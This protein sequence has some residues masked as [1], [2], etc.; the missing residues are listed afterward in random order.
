M[1]LKENKILTLA[2][3]E[4]YAPKNSNLTDDDDIALRLNP[5]YSL[6][7]QELA[8]KKKILKVYDFEKI[9]SDKTFY[10]EYEL[11]VDLY[12]IK[13]IIALDRDTYK[14]MEA[15]Y[16][17][18]G[19]NIYINDKS[20]CDYKLEYYAYPKAITTDVNDEVFELEIDQDVQFIL[21]YAVANDI[22]KVD[23][24]SDYSAFKVEYERKVSELD[25]RSI[26]SSISVEEVF[27]I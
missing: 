9:D 25:T 7:Y 1:T 21:P 3:I 6:R 14:D 10:R 18:V 2:L 17:F 11:P 20:N 19:K 16:K 4:E 5:I 8:T 24:S 12:Q 13:R 27:N 22:L 23:P 26:L 15:D